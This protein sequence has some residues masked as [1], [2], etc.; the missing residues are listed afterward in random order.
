MNVNNKIE[1]EFKF[2]SWAID[3]KTIIYVVVA[4]FLFVGISAYFS[5]PR[6]SFPEI[7]ETKY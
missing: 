3:H 2:S 7:K 1:K 5:M 6:E 4:I